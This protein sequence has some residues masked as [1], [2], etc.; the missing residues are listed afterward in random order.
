MGG[1]PDN[2][3]IVKDEYD[4]TKLMNSDISSLSLHSKPNVIDIDSDSE[5]SANNNL[6]SPLQSEKHQL[7]R[8]LKALGIDMK[9][10]RPDYTMALDEP[11]WGDEDDEEED[12]EYVY[13]EP[14]DDGLEILEYEEME[15]GDD[16]VVGKE[17]E[18]GSGSDVEMK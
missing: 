2:P 15:L 8:E 4:D 9:S 10:K 6:N 3:I 16:E 12:G 5:T 18:D 1:G 13:E 17:E 11:S 14:A 7:V